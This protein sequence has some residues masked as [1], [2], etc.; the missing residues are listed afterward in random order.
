VIA[1]K[2]CHSIIFA[3]GMNF[4]SNDHSLKKLPLSKTKMNEN[5]ARGHQTGDSSRRILR[6]DNSI[7]N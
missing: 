1:K 7:P 4:K 3:A 5:Q 6:I 2:K